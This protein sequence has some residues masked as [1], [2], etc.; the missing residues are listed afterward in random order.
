MSW[1][2]EERVEI[3]GAVRRRLLEERIGVV[4]RPQVRA[5]RSR[6][7]AASRSSS[8]LFQRANGSA[9]TRSASA[10][11]STSLPSSSSSVASESANQSRWPSPRAAS[12]RSRASSRTSSATDRADGLGRLPGLA[13]LGRVVALAEDAL[14]LVVVDLDPVHDAAVA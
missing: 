11:V 7:C 6:T 8:A 9:V 14:D 1:P 13:A 2:V 4:P 10:S 3:D 12:L 5:L